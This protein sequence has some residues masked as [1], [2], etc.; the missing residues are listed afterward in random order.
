MR[1]LSFRSLIEKIHISDI[2]GT[3]YQYCVSFSKYYTSSPYPGLYDAITIDHVFAS[4]AKLLPVYNKAADQ[5]PY[6]LIQ[7][8]PGVKVRNL[9]I[10]DMYRREYITPVET[11]RIY[12]G[13]EVESLILENI[14]TENYTQNE[15]MPVLVND[16]IIRHLDTK[17]IMENGKAAV[18]EEF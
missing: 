2:Y 11:I 6:P 15:Y 12:A 17:N 1:F 5:P 7:V 4:K 18:L 9:K 13:G 16:G 14:S 8:Q 3:F 10:A